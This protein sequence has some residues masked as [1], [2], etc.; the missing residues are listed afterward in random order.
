MD[1]HI[2]PKPIFPGFDIE[3]SNPVLDVLSSHRSVRKYKDKAVPEEALDRILSTAQRAPTSCNYQSYS[4]IVIS[5]PELKKKI[6]KYCSDQPFVSD[7]GVLLAF[8]ADIS[9][10]VYTCKMQGYRFRGNQVDTLLAAHGD[11]L[12]A[13]QN[14]AVSAESMGFG[15]CMVGN[16]RNHP[17]EVSDLLELP[18]YVFATVGLTIGY[19]DEDT[20]LKTRLPKRVIVSE[21]KYDTNNLEEDLTAYDHVMCDSGIY[22]GRIQPLSEVDPNLEDNY[23]ESNYGWIEHTA[24]RLGSC[25]QDQR[26]GFAAFLQKKG[27]RCR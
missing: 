24:R 12:L 26:R 22:H 16:I 7:C 4:I 25:V 14:A 8:C 18:K 3:G 13:C 15:T 20:G 23:S 1:D 27:F 10:I 21:N 11:A 5:D 17:Q 2:E 9:R 6:R 19:P